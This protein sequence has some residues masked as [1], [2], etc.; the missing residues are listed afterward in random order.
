MPVCFLFCVTVLRFRRSFLSAFLITLVWGVYGQNLVP[1]P[2]F[3]E[4]TS[5]PGSYSQHAAEFRAKN[6]RSANRGTPDQFHSCSKGEGGVPYNWAGISEAYEGNGYA[7]IYIWMIDKTFREYI[8]CKLL[9]P[10]VKDSVYKVGFRYRLSSYSKYS[11]DRI[12]LVFSDSSVD[13]THDKVIKATPSLSVVRDSALTMETGYWETLQQEYR[14]RGGE[15]YLVIGNFSDNAATHY[16]FIQFMPTQQEMLARSAYYY[17]D[18]VSVESKYTAEPEPI[19]PVPAFAV[20]TVETNKTYVLKNIQFEF[21]SYRLLYPSFAELEK[22]VSL[23]EQQP[24]I[25]IMLAGHTDDVGGDQY[26]RTLSRNRAKTVASYLISKGIP[27]NRV[28]YAG[29]GKSKPL[30]EGTSSEVRR[31]NRRVEATFMK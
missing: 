17:I 29:Y 19:S 11:V 2:G 31:I 23:M 6:W 8:Q 26:N 16:Y 15:Q 4:Y 3:E 12:G 25:K 10:L 5:C 30:M 20:E 13:A 1:N 7:G 24:N 28:E 18:D 27:A 14:A 9:Q 21:N 22:V